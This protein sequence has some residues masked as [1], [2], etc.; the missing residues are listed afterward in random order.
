MFRPLTVEQASLK[1]VKGWLIGQQ[2]Q[3]KEW[4][5]RYEIISFHQYGK[6]KEFTTVYLAKLKKDGARSGKGGDT[7]L[8]NLLPL[9]AAQRD[10]DKNGLSAA[11]FAAQIFA[12]GFVKRDWYNTNRESLVK[13][14]SISKTGRIKTQEILI[15]SG[16][17]AWTKKV[18]KQVIHSQEEFLINLAELEYELWGCEAKTFIPRLYNREWRFWNGGQYI[19]APTLKMTWLLD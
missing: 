6:Q 14:L 15:E 18:G 7:R 1:E 17:K 4:T 16:K 10:R 19:K 3:V 2:V 8:E 5:G 9:D 13:V 11:E 12:S